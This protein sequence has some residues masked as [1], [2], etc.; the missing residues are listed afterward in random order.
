MGFTPRSTDLPQGPKTKTLYLKLSHAKMPFDSA[1]ILFLEDDPAYQKVVTFALQK[2]GFQV[3]AAAQAAAALECA[4]QERFDLVI[5]D[6]HLP[7]STGTDFVDRLREIDGH[8]RVPVIF[9]TGKAEE[10]SQQDL[11][12]GLLVVSKLSSMKCLAETVSRCL[13]E[14]HGES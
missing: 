9:L 7:D 5:S 13:A 6:Y 2:K 3:T 12:K 4:E 11:G 1:H 14:A 8:Q 10:F